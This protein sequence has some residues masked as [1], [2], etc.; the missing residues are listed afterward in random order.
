MGVGRF[1]GPGLSVPVGV[2]DLGIQGGLN[3]CGGAFAPGQHV[4]TLPGQVLEEGRGPAAAV[5]ADQDPPVVPDDGAQGRQEPAQFPGQRGPGFGHDHQH[6][7]AV[8]VG[9]PVSS[10][11]GTGNFNLVEWTFPIFLVPW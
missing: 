3:V 1:P 6:R 4:K 2:G 10:V 8:G 9:D 7:G 11:A 5:E